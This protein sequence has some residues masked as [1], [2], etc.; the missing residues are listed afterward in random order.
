MSEAAEGTFISKHE[1]GGDNGKQCL[2]VARAAAGR[3]AAPQQL[4]EPAASPPGNKR[5]HR[6]GP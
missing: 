2:H 6:H 1:M 5:P 3:V 4:T